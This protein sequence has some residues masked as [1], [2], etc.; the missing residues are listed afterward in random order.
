MDLN[1]QN[2]F[3]DTNKS[4]LYKH[5]NRIYKVFKSYVSEALES[6]I[7]YNKDLR[8]KV[9]KNIILP[10][11]LLRDD[12]GWLYGYTMKYINGQT[13]H[14]EIHNQTLSFEDKIFIINEFFEYLQELHQ[15]LTVGDV[16][17]SNLM[18][19]KDRRAYMID[20]DFAVKNNS[21]R[22]PIASYRIAYGEDHINDKS[23]DIIKLFISALS[24]LYNYNV[25]FDMIKNNDISFLRNFVPYSGSLKEYYYYLV[26]KV[27][28][29]EP[30]TEY[31]KIPIDENVE[32]DIMVKKR[33]AL[34]KKP[35]TL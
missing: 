10:T 5:H 13:I 4:R 17:N 25:E 6:Q 28:R 15:Y 14:H 9:S 1:K 12:K 33:D 3:Y 16:R 7:I 21:P 26:N 23:G 29:Y 11:S 34:T 31:L 22:I 2:E 18:I 8:K 20:L 24:L 32:K 35:T 30:I 27:Y 19:G